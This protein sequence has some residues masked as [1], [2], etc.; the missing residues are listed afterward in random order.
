MDCRHARMCVF[1]VRV[2]VCVLNLYDVCVR[3]RV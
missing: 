2:R 1:H 3:V